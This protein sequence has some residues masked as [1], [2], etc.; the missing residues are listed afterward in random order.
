MW[1]SSW[2]YDEELCYLQMLNDGLESCRLANATGAVVP[3]LDKLKKEDASIVQRHPEATN[4]FWIFDPNTGSFDTYLLRLA[5]AET[6]R[7][8]CVAAIALKRYRLQHGAYPATL[9]DLVPAI[10][11]AVPTDFMDGKPLRYR[12]RPDGDFLLYSVGEDGRDDDGDP[13]P[14]SQSTSF[15]WLLGRDIVWPRVATPAALEEY[16]RLSKSVTNVP[17]Q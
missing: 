5:Q 7:R 17:G 3:A 10:L 12:L 2:S 8:L 15:Y 14:A 13:T 16:H 6:G 4:H 9:N 11:P 1:K